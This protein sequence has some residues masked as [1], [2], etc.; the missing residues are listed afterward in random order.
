M[1]KTIGFDNYKNHLLNV[2]STSIYRSQLFRNNKH[3]IH[4]VEVNKVAMNRNDDKQIVKKDGIST[5]ECGQYSLCWNSLFEL[6][7]TY[8]NGKSLSSLVSPQFQSNT[9]TT[10]VSLRLVKVVSKYLSITTKEI[11]LPRIEN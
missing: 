11:L 9:M 5:L 4:T 7:S 1:K 2:R 3:E 10:I 6:R 8:L